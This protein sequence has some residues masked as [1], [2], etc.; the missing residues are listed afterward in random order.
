MKKPKKT[1]KIFI[2]LSICLLLVLSQSIYVFAQDTF[3]VECKSAILIDAKSGKV[4]YEKNIH[5]K[6][7]PAS[8]TKIMLLLLSM[9][10]LE[11]ER[12]SLDDE[13]VI[14]QNA[15]SMGGSQVYLEAGETNTVEELLKAICV[16]SANDAA[17]ALGEH[18]AG[19]EEMF[20][21]MMNEK[22][23][24]LNM[25]NTNFMNITGLPDENH[26]TSAYDISIMSAELLKYSQIHKW[27]T[28]WMASI[29]VGKDNDVKQQLVNTNKL[30]RFYKGANGIKTGYTSKAGHCLSASAQR[31]NLSLISV[32][33]G[34]RSSNIR[35]NE[36]RKLLDYGFANY[37]SKKICNKNDVIDNIDI[38]KGKKENMDIVAEDDLNVLIKKGQKNNIEKEIVL[39]KI[40][41]APLKKNQKVGEMIIKVRG[42]ETDRISLIAKEEVRKASVTD[43]FKKVFVKALSK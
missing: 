43:M 2:I 4:M 26:Y 13:V 42:K 6:L 11:N 22:A 30:I 31:G 29:M 19:T 35:F 36:S 33:L 21:K 5:E 32:V 34:C 7:P 24:E 38:N 39:P 23:K 9:E 40:I 12:I 20:V 37:D 27:L 14:T 28:L 10:S 1:F 8:I 18:I 15:S 3:D 17:V 16:R 25:K 41:R